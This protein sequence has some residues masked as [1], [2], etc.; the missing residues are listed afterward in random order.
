[1]FILVVW[2]QNKSWQDS[3]FV[4]EVTFLK[5]RTKIIRIWANQISRSWSLACPRALSESLHTI[6][7]FYLP[8]FVSVPISITKEDRLSF[9]DLLIRHL[10]PFSGCHGNLCPCQGPVLNIAWS[11]A[12]I[13]LAWISRVL[14]FDRVKDVRKGGSMANERTSEENYELFAEILQAAS[15]PGWTAPLFFRFLGGVFCSRHLQAM[16]NSIQPF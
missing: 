14:S 2:L 9:Y 8:F 13:V 12:S 7:L 5:Q 3:W 10:S 1:M 6:F 16:R 11:L 15:W 4:P